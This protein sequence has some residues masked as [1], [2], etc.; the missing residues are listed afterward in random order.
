MLLETL[1]GNEFTNT[2]FMNF[3]FRLDQGSQRPKNMYIFY[4]MW[5][6]FKFIYLYVYIYIER[7]RDRENKRWYPS[8]ACNKLRYLVCS[9]SHP[10][11]PLLYL[12]SLG[13]WRYCFFSYSTYGC[14]FPPEVLYIQ[15]IAFNH[16]NQQEFSRPASPPV[17]ATPMTGFHDPA[18]VAKQVELQCF[19]KSKA[20][21][22]KCIIVQIDLSCQ[23]L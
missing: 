15:K 18:A 7:E 3:P 23:C 16:Q 13:I 17:P 12:L 2:W 4:C 9:L 22:P 10:L 14:L 19:C 6:T 20:F 1:M 11:L 21:T 5:L 8:K